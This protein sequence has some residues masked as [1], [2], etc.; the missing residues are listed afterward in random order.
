MGLTLRCT[1]KE[2]ELAPEAWNSSGVVT[3]CCV[4]CLV[5]GLELP[6]SHPRGALHHCEPPSSQEAEFSPSEYINP[7]GGETKL[8]S[9]SHTLV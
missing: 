7:T 2:D 3:F 9:V 4:R 8:V 6:D 1:A 5:P